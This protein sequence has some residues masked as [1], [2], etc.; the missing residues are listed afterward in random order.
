MYRE[1][2]IY[3]FNTQTQ[4][5]GTLSSEHSCT[6]IEFEILATGTHFYHYTNQDTCQLIGSSWL[7][8]NTVTTESHSQAYIHLM[9]T[10]R[11]SC[12]KCSHVS[13]HSST[14]MYC[15]E[16]KP[17]SGRL[18]TRQIISRPLATPSHLL[19]VSGANIVL[20]QSHHK[21]VSAAYLSWC[22]A[23]VQF[24]HIYILHTHPRLVQALLGCHTAHGVATEAKEA[25]VEGV[26]QVSAHVLRHNLNCTVLHTQA[27]KTMCGQVGW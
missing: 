8:D 19:H 2:L 1:R 22:K 12:D 18:I 10:W 24:H 3:H 21:Q 23:V 4:H 20:C 17:K 5:H 27:W 9:F 6:F 25:V 11:N 13:P 16:C 14:S 15:W 26:G 7:T